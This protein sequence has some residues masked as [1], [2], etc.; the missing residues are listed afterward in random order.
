MLAVVE[1]QHRLRPAQAL[2][3]RRLAADDAERGDDRVEHVVRGLR[4]LEP[5]EPDGN[6]D[7]R[8]SRRDRERRLADTAWADDLDERGD[9][10]EGRAAPRSRRRA[11]RA[12]PQATAGCPRA[13][14]SDSSWVRIWLLDLL[15]PRPRLEAE[16]VREAGADALVGGQRVGL[17]ALTVERGDQQ[18]PQ[19][20]PVRSCRDGGIE[21]ADHV[22][23]EPQPRREA[24]L[25][26]LHS[27]L[28]EPGSLRR[29]PVAG[30][31]QHVSAEER[32]RGRAGRSGG[33]VV[34]VVEQRRRR[35]DVAQHPVRVHGGGLDREPVAVV[36]AGDD[37]GSPRLRR[38]RATFCCS[39]LRLVGVPAQR[40]SSSR[41]A[42]TGVP[43]ASARCTSS[44]A[45]LP[46]GIA[47]GLPSR[48]TSTGPS[49]RNSSTAR[50]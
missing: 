46:P 6:L 22:L 15:Q 42:R 41:S 24:G 39:V 19:P 9:A 16:L 48:L 21:L 36:A 30:R 50:V 13:T 12:R 38:R 34:A 4:G 23:A 2:L 47:T 26:E 3:Q 10:P 18:L 37:D 49:T 40:S 29:G 14:P 20:L 17:P 1:D 33:R 35:V 27:R 45:V 32:Q 28:L 7:Q 8:A 11:P 25:H 44:S 31:R 43:A 5:D